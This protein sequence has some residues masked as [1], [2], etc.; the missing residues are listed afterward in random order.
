MT[1]A[2]VLSL[3]VLVG[4]GVTAAQ[5]PTWYELY[6][7]AIKH[8]Q[9]GEFD[10]AE[11]K[12]QRAQKEGPAPGRGVL[13]YGSQRTAFFPDY[14]LGI[15]YVST[16]RPQQALAAFER[17]RNANLNTRDGEFRAI[18]TFEAQAKTALA[19]ADGGAK[20]PPVTVPGPAVTAPPPATPP[21]TSNPAPVP[22]ADYAKQFADTLTQARAQLAQ[23]NFD[24]AEQTASSARD[25]AIKYTLTT[26]RPRADELLK[27]I[28]G[29]RLAARVEAALERRDAAAARQALNVLAAA[30][31]TY[32]ADALRTRVDALERE[33]RS[34]TLQ[35]SAVRAFLT[36]NYEQAVTLL[37]EAAGVAALPPR[38]LFYR[39]CSLAA[40]AAASPDPAS[41]PRLPAARRTYA[42]AGSD[43]QFREDLRYVSPKVK[44]LLG[45]K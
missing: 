34:S 17:A 33:V 15:V 26:E 3:L 45:I 39:A 10:Q 36:G 41:D 23:R 35:R 6:D 24:A 18:T 12:L 40:L 14:Y 19:R 4:P 13:R 8:I 43:S 37:E 42:S 11:T 22:T 32:R 28:S 29:G 7:Q 38:A 9:Q 20:P 2:L 5:E 1:F 25:L 31:P 27:E 16:G 21:A 30:E 44:Q